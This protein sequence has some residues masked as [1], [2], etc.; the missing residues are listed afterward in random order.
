LFDTWCGEL[1]FDD[2]NR[3]A[4]PPSISGLGNLFLSFTTEGA[5]HFS[6]RSRNRANVLTSSS[7]QM[8]IRK[9]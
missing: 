2:Y 6:R 3:F 4:L 7:G 1:G 9:S 5:H 8:E